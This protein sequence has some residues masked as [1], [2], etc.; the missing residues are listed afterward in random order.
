MRDRSVQTS[1]YLGI[2]KVHI[3]IMREVL[4]PC[5]F[6]GFY[7]ETFRENRDAKNPAKAV[8]FIYISWL[9]LVFG[10]EV[11]CR[12]QNCVAGKNGCFH[13]SCFSPKKNFKTCL[14]FCLVFATSHETFY[15]FVFPSGRARG[16]C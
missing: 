13:Q 9:C 7:P 3:Q 16:A 14:C 10:F 6:L 5:F 15:F 8:T 1:I 4:V 11:Q 12:M 2:W